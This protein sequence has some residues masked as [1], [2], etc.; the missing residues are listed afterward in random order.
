MRLATWSLTLACTMALAGPLPAQQ[1]DAA[2]LLRLVRS[3]DQTGRVLVLT[4]RPEEEPAALVAWLHHGLGA[5]VGVLALHRGEA[6]VNR[7]GRE[8]GT[9]LGVL[10]V[11]EMLRVREVAGGRQYVTRAYDFGL[12]DSVAGVWPHWP[13]DL[14]AEDLIT[15]VRSFRPHVLILPC[16]APDGIPDAHRGA[17]RLVAEDAFRLAT[18]TTAHSVFSSGGRPPWQPVRMYRLACDAEAAPLIVDAGAVEPLLGESYAQIGARAMARQQS[19]GLAVEIRPGPSRIGLIPVAPETSP[20]PRDLLDGITTGWAGRAAGAADDTA[21]G[22]SLTAVAAAIHSLQSGF[23][24]RHPDRA[25]PHLAEALAR[26]REAQATLPGPAPPF[27]TWSAASADLHA[28]LGGAEDR[29]S[30]LLVAAAGIEVRLD[31]PAPTVAAG[32]SLPVTLTV[33]NR[34]SAPVRVLGGRA[35]LGLPAALPG[36]AD[37]ST[38]RPDESRSWTVPLRALDPSV[39][40]WMRADRPGDYYHYPPGLSGSPGLLSGEEAAR[41]GRATLHLE[42]RGAALSLVTDPIAA[43]HLDPVRGE[44]RTPVAVMPPITVLLERVLDFTAADRQFRRRLVVEVRSWT[45]RPREV[46]VRIRTPPGVTASDSV[47][48]ILL[49]P[50]ERTE[51]SVELQGRLP[52]ERHVL[53]VV[54]ESEGTTYLR[55]V[56]PVGYDHTD[57]SYVHRPAALWLDATPVTAPAGGETGYLPGESDFTRIALRQVDVPVTELTAANLDSAGLARYRRIAVG[58]GVFR[59]PEV[60]RAASD[61]L[62]WVARGGRLVILGGGEELHDAGVLPVE[63]ALGGSSRRLVGSTVGFAPQGENAPWFTRPN[64]LDEL[65]FDEWIVPVARSLPAEVPPGFRAII[66]AYPA[67]EGPGIPV[68]WLTTIGRG[69]LVYT[70]LTLPRQVLAGEAGAIRLLVNLLFAPAGP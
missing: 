69:S 27:F 45:D 1:A 58:P 53:H 16:E 59:D 7:F 61:L 40:W 5:D 37:S 52:R 33:F 13:R 12:A 23:D 64:R 60:R 54:A 4:A 25:A 14:L 15:V 46:T 39:A 57:R 36:P 22:R 66:A 55:G 6:G 47:I 50:G 11:Q 56:I 20:P 19:Q 29:L 67:A 41:P 2:T 32:D 44:V 8:V 26:I 49:A 17:L 30:R 34:G 3:L 9:A 62:H 48:P 63:F 10:R 31:A 43:S 65:D 51:L 21:R 38:I 35:S 24:P 18:D 70:G 42:V 68:A 28:A